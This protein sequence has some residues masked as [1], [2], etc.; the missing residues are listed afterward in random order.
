MRIYTGKL[1]RLLG[2]YPQTRSVC[3]QKNMA[4]FVGGDWQPKIDLLFWSLGE[5]AYPNVRIYE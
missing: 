2:V 1:E 5:N 4:W 3:I